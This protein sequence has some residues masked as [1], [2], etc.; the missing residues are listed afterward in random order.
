LSLRRPG[1]DRGRLPRTPGSS[2]SSAATDWKASG[3]SAVARRARRVA[4]TQPRT[5][6]KDSLRAVARLG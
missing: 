4:R 2:L 3:R 1:R 5:F 6:P